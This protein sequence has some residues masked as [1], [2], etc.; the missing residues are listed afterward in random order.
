MPQAELLASWDVQVLVSQLREALPDTAAAEPGIE[1][2]SGRVA[3]SHF[4]SRLTVAV[5]G[6]FLLLGFAATGC[7]QGD[8]AAV[9]EASQ[10]GSAETEPTTNGGEGGGGGLGAGGGAVG[11]GAVGSAIGAVASGGVSCNRGE[12]AGKCIPD[13][14]GAGFIVDDEAA[15]V[16]E[17]TSASGSCSA[18]L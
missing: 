4:A 12:T 6:G 15:G 11:S 7:D 17:T 5:L 13:S 2:A 1:P 14:T 16:R 8:P 3:L 9:A 10:D 18:I